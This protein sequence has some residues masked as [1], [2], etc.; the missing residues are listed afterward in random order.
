MQFQ[1]SE[2]ELSQRYNI[3]ETTITRDFKRVQAKLYKQGIVVTKIKIKGE[4]V[5][6]VN[7]EYTN[8]CNTVGFTDFNVLRD[9]DNMSCNILLSLS[10]LDM[11]AFGGYVNEF[12]YNHLELECNQYQRSLFFQSIEK[13]EK[14]QYVMY[15]FD[16]S[17]KNCFVI[18]L[19]TKMRRALQ[20][21]QWFIQMCKDIA[22][23]N[24]MKSYI[25]LFKVIVALC[26]LTNDLGR[27]SCITYKNITE[28][29]GMS[30]Y[31]IRKAFDVL[32]KE[33]KI[34][35][36]KLQYE[37]DNDGELIKCRGRVVEE[38]LEDRPVQILEDRNAI[39][40]DST[41]KG[42]VAIKV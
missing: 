7:Q 23:Q 12:L 2:K 37:I 33:G 20:F 41:Y 26:I 30:T 28:I 4:R 38:N 35:I 16:P 3:S 10:S 29:T 18:G 32:T 5:Y 27:D 15:K 6:V 34:N 8:E 14:E 24:N 42:E 19:T 25:P 21:R 22:L 9:M 39:A 40:W 17:D 31:K 13:L 11:N 36:G 1:L